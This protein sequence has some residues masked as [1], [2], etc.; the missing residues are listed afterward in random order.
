M[1]ANFQTVTVPRNKLTDKQVHEWFRD[2]QEELT[3]EYGHD[4]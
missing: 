1:G 4:A 3:Y 2:Y